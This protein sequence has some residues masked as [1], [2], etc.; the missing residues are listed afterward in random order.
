MN[1]EAHMIKWTYVELVC[2]KTVIRCGNLFYFNSPVVVLS[3]TVVPTMTQTQISFHGK[4][5]YVVMNIITQP[6]IY[7]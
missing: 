5:G 2:S 1:K 6:N 7:R 3:V 4:N